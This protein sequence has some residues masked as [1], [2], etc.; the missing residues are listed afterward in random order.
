MT[1]GKDDL[2]KGR[3]ED[4]VGDLLCDRCEF[5]VVPKVIEDH[6]IVKHISRDQLPAVKQESVKCDYCHKALFGGNSLM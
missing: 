6:K 1:S 2:L 4:K 3:N 5:E